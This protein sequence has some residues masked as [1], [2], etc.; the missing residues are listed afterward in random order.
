MKVVFIICLYMLCISVLPLISQEP[1]SDTAWVCPMH[2]DYTM[3]IAGKCPRCGMDLVR[4]SPFDVRD[5]RL[6]FRTVPAVVKPGQKMK[7]LFRI[8]HPGTGEPIEKF[9]VVHE[10][11]YHLFVISQNMEYF[12]HIHP[13]Q[14]PDGTWSIDVTLPKAGYYKLL[15]DFMPSGGSSQFIA[16]PLVTAGY[17]GDLANDSARLVA[18]RV[19]TKAVDDVTA[20]LAYDPQTFSVGQYGHLNFHLTD[21]ASGRP[22]TDLQ[23]YLGAFGHTLIMSEDMADYVHSHPLDILARENDDGGPP[24]FMIPPG[25]DLEK[26]RG[27]PDVTFEGLMP[28]PGRYRAW[29]QFRRNDKIYTFAF[30]FNVVASK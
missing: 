20:T 15:S 19:L 11:Q 21:T 16:R 13:E 14:Q 23:T 5:Y 3:D 6:D 28:K 24:Q 10:R 26:L 12:Q 25:A 17:R 29:T 8:L 4:A 9:E 22:I 30:T 2:G 18:D 27:G 7:L 1:Q